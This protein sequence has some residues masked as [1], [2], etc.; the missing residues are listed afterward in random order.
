MNLLIGTF[1]YLVAQTLVW[2]QLYGPLKIE[3]MKDKTWL[4]Y[5]MSIPITHVFVL[6]TRYT[7]AAMDGLTWGS[8]FVQFGAGIV[9]FMV[10]AYYFNN[11]GISLKTGLSLILVFAIMC[12][13][14]ILK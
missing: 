13:Q 12:I 1:Y 10:L 7:I 5:A 14:I 6:A 2:I 9:T 3:Y 4:V 8:R 11:E